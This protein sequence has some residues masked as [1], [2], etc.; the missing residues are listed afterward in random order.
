MIDGVFF[1]VLADPGRISRRCIMPIEEERRWIE[2]QTA[3]RLS[4]DHSLTDTPAEV[5]PPD[6][7]AARAG[8]EGGMP[9]W[10]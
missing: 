10:T 1:L 6:R 3:D 9:C 7:I 8:F 2:A 4:A 5:S